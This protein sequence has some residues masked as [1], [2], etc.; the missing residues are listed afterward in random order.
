MEFNTSRLN[1]LVVSSKLVHLELV[2]LH[3]SAICIVVSHP[4]FRFSF[5][6]ENCRRGKLNLRVCVRTDSCASSLSQS[7]QKAS[8]GDAA[9]FLQ[10]TTKAGLNFTVSSWRLFCVFISL[11]MD[12]PLQY[13]HRTLQQ[14]SSLL[15]P[16]QPLCL[17]CCALYSY[18]KRKRVQSGGGQSLLPC[19][20]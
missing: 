1:S 3:C 12:N 10:S 16:P 9:Y 6:K 19:N 15:S 20:K 2:S 14:N 5:L 8:S 11:S 7:V 18:Q 4:G 17:L 13:C